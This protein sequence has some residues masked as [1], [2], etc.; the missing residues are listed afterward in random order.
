MEKGPAIYY[1]RRFMFIGSRRRPLSRTVLWVQCDF[2]TG[3]SMQSYVNIVSNHHAHPDD[4]VDAESVRIHY[5]TCVP[6]MR[7]TITHI[8][9]TA[10]QGTDYL[11]LHSSSAIA[12]MYDPY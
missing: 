8:I 6:V 10:A 5:C 3:T 4:P 2:G 1:F 12:Y 9:S 7:G 11:F